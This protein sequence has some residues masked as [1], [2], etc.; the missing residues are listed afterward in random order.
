MTDGWSWVPCLI[1]TKEHHNQTDAIEFKPMDNNNDDKSI[2][3]LDNFNDASNVSGF[4]IIEIP[5]CEHN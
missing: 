2:T 1:I 3:M 5:A 4:G